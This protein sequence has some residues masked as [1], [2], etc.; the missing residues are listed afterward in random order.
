MKKNLFL[1]A[2]FFWGVALNAQELKRVTVTIEYTN[3][4]CGG[5][6]PSAE[7]LEK[8]K[9]KNKLAG[10]VLRLEEEGGGKPV[11]VKTDAEGKFSKDMKLGTYN[12]FLTKKI[13]KKTKSNVDINCKKM[14]A[15]S[16][17]QLVIAKGHS[18]NYAITL[19]FGCSPCAPAKP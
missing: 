3:A 8:S 4:Y 1:A 18:P 7:A 16:Y 2:I 10:W 15:R 6:K 17:G 5:G 9:A 12:V 11:M 13:N 19:G 14:M